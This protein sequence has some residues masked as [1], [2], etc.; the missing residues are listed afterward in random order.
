MGRI[1]Y[2]GYN[3]LTQAVSDLTASN[4]PS[5]N[6]GSIFSMLYGICTVIFAISFFIYYKGRL[7]KFVTLGA[8]AFCIMAIVSFL[9]YSFFPLSSSDY[10][11]TVQD[12]MHI[13]ITIF[14]VAFIIISLTLFCIGFFR[15]EK[16]K[17]LG[18][19]SLCAFI[20]L[21]IGAILVNIVPKEYFG[22]AE[23]I[24]IYSVIIYT[25]V[26]SIWMYKYINSGNNLN[27][28]NGDK[29]DN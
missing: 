10:A 27:K 23:R 1:F 19:I 4:S 17:S 7:N 11:G 5:R 22:V 8:V 6:I 21:A 15:T 9:G 18:I 29:Y 24:N 26:L 20:F 13:L 28:K 12:K 14:V 25:C 3:P 16:Y 2:T